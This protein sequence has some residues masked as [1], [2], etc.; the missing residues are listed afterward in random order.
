MDTKI[1][2]ANAGPAKEFIHPDYLGSIGLIM[3]YSK[4]F[5]ADCNRLRISSKAELYLCLFAEQ[6]QS[7]RELL[8]SEDPQPLIDFYAPHYNTKRLVTICTIKSPAQPVI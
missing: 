2:S 6:H 7:M 1:R 8:Q 5:C 3:P 4:N